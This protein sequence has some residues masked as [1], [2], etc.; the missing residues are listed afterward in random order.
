MLE[1]RKKSKEYLIIAIA[2]LSVITIGFTVA[3]FQGQIGSGATANVT[4]TTK[5]TDVLTFNKGNDINITVTQANFGQ[6]AGNRT[7]STTATA[8]LLANNDTNSATNT[9]NVYLLITNNNFEY[10][11]TPTN[12]PELMLTITNP[13][14]EAVTSISGLTYTTSGGVS[15]FDITTKN[16]LIQIASNYSI[17]S[18][19]TKTDTWN[20]TVTLV[21]LNSDQQLN[22]GK[23]L[24]AR[25]IIQKEEYEYQVSYANCN[26]PMITND[27]FLNCDDDLL[28]CKVAKDFDYTDIENSKVVLHNGIV[29]N[30]SGCAILDAEDRSYRYTGGDYDVTQT[31]I[32]AGYSYV[33]T[34]YGN[35]T[36]GVIGVNCNGTNQYVGY[37]NSAC[38]TKY[39]YL[40]YD[41]NVTQYSTYD[42]AASQAITDGYI[43][44]RNLNNY[45]C[46]GYDTSVAANETTCPEQNLYRIIGAFDDD[47]DGNYN[48]K[49]I[50]S[51]YAS[52]TEFGTNAQ[53]GTSSYS[54][55]YTSSQY[56][57]YHGSKSSIQ[58]F[59][60]FGTNENYLNNWIYSTFRSEVLN[61]Y[62]LNIYLKENNIKWN[63]MLE[64]A[65]YYSGGPMASGNDSYSPKALYN[66][67]RTAEALYNSSTLTVDNYIGLIYSSDFGFASKTSSWKE[68]A[69][70]NYTRSSGNDWLYNGVQE[71]TITHYYGPSQVLTVMTIGYLPAYSV[72]NGFAARPVLY[73]DSGVE[74]LRGL[75]TKA[76][77]Y[78]VGLPT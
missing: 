5:T 31:A 66:T 3:Y 56:T 42:A 63:N 19:G 62:Y 34:Y 39:Y 15:G 50:K 41:S 35:T 78:Y 21:N 40:L 77:P 60:W 45:V 23:T 9:Y 17:T 18:T 10:T 67:E 20:V 33:N 36:G 61:N 57:G 64:E 1:N 74:V 65:S 32:S 28:A 38:S 72:Y 47:N 16:G 6:G 22:T 71:L 26:N 75:G 55:S 43:V 46:F 76:S 59:L 27:Y 44:A 11:T 14:N 52:T 25:V 48:I 73:L 54:S 8:T 24:S 29:L 68:T 13:N 12:T 70:Y 37:Q 7:G 30:P 53:N 4:V 51:D 2:I 69:K 49:L 58:S